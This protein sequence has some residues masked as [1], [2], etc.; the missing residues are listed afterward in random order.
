MDNLRFAGE[1]NVESI[2]IKSIGSS[3]TMEVKNQ[4]IGINIYE[5]LFSPFITG[6]LS[7]KDSLDILN[8]IPLV[9]EELVTIKMSTPSIN[10]KISI[11]FY[12]YKM[13]DR[14]YIADRSVAY[15][16]H[17]ISVEAIKDINIKISKSFSG[18]ITDIMANL[19]RKEGGL[20]TNKPFLF[21]DTASNVKFVSNF[22]KPTSI[23]NFL[24]DRAVSKNKSPSYIFFENRDGFNFITLEN[25][26]SQPVVQ[27][28]NYNNFS[29]DVQLGTA[30]RNIDMDYKRVIDLSIP[31]N[32]DYLSD[33]ESGRFA[34][35]LFSYDVTTKQYKL[36]NFD[37][38]KDFY[39]GVHLNKYPAASANITKRSAAKHVFGYMYNQYDTHTGYG[40]TTSG[41]IDFQDR[42]STLI[43][44]ESNKVNITVPGRFDYTVGR[45]VYLKLYKVAPIREEESASD[46]LD[47]IN[48]GNYIISAINHSIIRGKNTH[49]CYIE[50]IKDSY[51]KDLN[52][53]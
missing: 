5:D 16:L 32:F 29:K 50:L 20:N 41:N 2:Q 21:E 14:T 25:L 15:S 49:T 30:Y 44:A 53:A 4:V 13:A 37:Y 40:L 46:L 26:Y 52:I 27:E 39:K 9:G 33:T 31:K 8:A 24:C 17:F 43:S 34:S 7:M 22:W 11:D 28:F 36:K 10:E 47:E 51:I 3:R 48:S 23:I 42:F 35:K 18:K 38:Y 12:V 1:V 45:K 6:S 19:V